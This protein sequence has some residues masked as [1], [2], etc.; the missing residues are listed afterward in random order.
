[1]SLLSSSSFY[2][3]FIFYFF[4]RRPFYPYLRKTRETTKWMTFKHWHWYKHTIIFHITL[5]LLLTII[6]LSWL[7]CTRE[8]QRKK[9]LLSTSFY[10]TS[11]K[12]LSCNERFNEGRA[13]FPLYNI[14]HVIYDP[15]IDHIQIYSHFI[16]VWLKCKT[17]SLCFT[18]IHFS[19]LTLIS[20]IFNH[21]AFKFIQLYFS[22]TFKSFS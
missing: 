17:Y 4:Q 1:M 6:I 11:L 3:F 16:E 15:F 22:S 18:K 19:H 5:K 7:K 21:L 20:F 14:D 10:Y 2:F 13:H 12:Y 9:Y 8:E